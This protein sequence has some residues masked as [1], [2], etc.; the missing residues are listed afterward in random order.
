MRVP[1]SQ[2]TSI[3]TRAEKFRQ[4]RC[5]HPESRIEV[6]KMQASCSDFSGSE[7][8]AISRNASIVSS[9]K[10]DRGRRPPPMKSFLSIA[11]VR[12]RTLTIVRHSARW[13]LVNPEL[14]ELIRLRVEEALVGPRQATRSSR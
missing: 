5:L 1:P 11:C 4:S 12:D 10:E 13:R 14:S 8:W 3:V 7:D 6:R 9:E 2:P